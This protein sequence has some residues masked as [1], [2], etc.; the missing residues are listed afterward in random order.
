MLTNSP[1]V[2]I[3]AWLLFW[4]VLAWALWQGAPE[5]ARWLAR[6]SDPREDIHFF[7]DEL[8]GEPGPGMSAAAQGENDPSGGAAGTSRQAR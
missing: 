1:A 6:D 2:L 4:L 8:R 7:Q 5:L 3:C